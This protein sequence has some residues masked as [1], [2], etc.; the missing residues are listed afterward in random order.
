MRS[1]GQYC[2]V[3][4]ALDV[5]GDRWTLLKKAGER[6]DAHLHLRVVAARDVLQHLLQLPALLADGD[7]VVHEG[8]KLPAALER[9]GDALALADRVAR[10]LDDAREQG[11][12]DDVLHDVERGE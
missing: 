3:A 9:R 7:H 12:V 11:V 10:I 2:S 6:A 5:I 4:K 1:Y 8:G